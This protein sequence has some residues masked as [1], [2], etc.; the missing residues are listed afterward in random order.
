MNDDER[1]DIDPGLDQVLGASAPNVT[2]AGRA[3]E[4]VIGSMVLAAKREA[5]SERGP[6]SSRRMA[7]MAVVLGLGLGGVGAAA[8]AVTYQEWSPWAQD[9]DVAFTYT[10]PSG[11]VCEERLGEVVGPDPATVEATRTFFRT[12]DVLALA[13]VEGT[14]A[15]LRTEE[16]TTM[17]DSG[18]L[19]S[20]TNGSE[21]YLSPDTEYHL[22]LT[23][24]VLELV[25]DELAAQGF[26]RDANTYTYTGEA[27]CPGAQ[28]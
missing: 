6:K 12:H 25:D 5:A 8:A 20:A 7:G 23:R 3:D 26:D 28:W 18:T 11:A 2:L 22:A 17:D 13:D 21:D 4:Q 9:P 1:Y 27:H 24:A 10:L 16:H 19:R 15:S 14:I